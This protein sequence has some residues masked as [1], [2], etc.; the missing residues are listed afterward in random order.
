MWL[1]INCSSASANESSPSSISILPNLLCPSH[2]FVILPIR[3]TLPA[4]NTFVV[5]FENF[6]I[7]LSNSTLVSLTMNATMD[8]T[9]LNTQWQDTIYSPISEELP[10]NA[11]PPHGKPVH[12]TCFFDANL[13]HDLITGHSATS[14]LHMLNQ[15]QGAWTSTRQHQVKTATYGSEFM[16]THQAVEQ[17][18]NICYT[19]HMFGGPAWVL[20]DNQAIINRMT[21]PHSSLSNIGMHFPTTNAR[22]LLLPVFV[23]SNTS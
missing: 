18:I 7:V 14:L 4:S 6:H 21:I 10:M 11:P 17:V 3:T 15:T 16:A 22:K 1:S 13:M 9:P 2:A 23:G 19:L 5:I 8:C 12:H 20:G